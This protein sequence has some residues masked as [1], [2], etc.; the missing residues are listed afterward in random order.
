MGAIESGSEEAWLEEAMHLARAY[1]MTVDDL[2]AQ[3]HGWTR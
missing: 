1:D 2:A 3:V